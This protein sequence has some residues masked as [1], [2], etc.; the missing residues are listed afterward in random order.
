MPSIYKQQKKNADAKICRHLRW[1]LSTVTG[2]WTALQKQSEGEQTVV[3]QDTRIVLTHEK[4]Q[5]SKIHNQ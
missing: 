2:N 3:Y 1:V 4:D 5:E